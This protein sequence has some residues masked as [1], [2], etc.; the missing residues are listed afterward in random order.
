[1]DRA[2]LLPDGLVPVDPAATSPYC[3]GQP[4]AVGNKGRC[5]RVCFKL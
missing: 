1:M 2:S 3:E 5:V 4:S